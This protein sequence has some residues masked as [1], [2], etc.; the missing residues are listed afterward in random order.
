MIYE[1]W[2]NFSGHRFVRNSVAV[3]GCTKT[4]QL[5]LTK[6]PVFNVGSKI[7]HLTIDILGIKGTSKWEFSTQTQFWTQKATVKVVRVS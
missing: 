5:T 6:F 7:R 1:G 3:I 2:P 4:Q